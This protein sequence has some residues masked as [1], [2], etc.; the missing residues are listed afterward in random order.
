MSMKQK[1]VKFFGALLIASG[2]III[3]GS[4][5]FNRE[6]NI[7]R[8]A[9]LDEFRQELE[10]VKEAS[11]EM[12]VSSEDNSDS[13]EEASIEEADS[14]EKPLSGKVIGI[15]TI[16]S[17][18]SES[19]IREGVSQNVLADSLGHEP[20]TAEPG[21]V[22]NC[23]IAGH[24]NYNFNRFFSRLDKVK[25]GDYI[26]VETLDDTYS[27]EVFDIKVVEPDDLSVLD[28]T[29]DEII[30]LYTCTP[31]YIGT[32]RLVVSAKRVEE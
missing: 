15:L 11:L 18:E 23:V 5:A 28:N 14:T 20:D 2:L 26:Q 29:D 12:N 9:A 22:G 10:E 24:R 25:L 27:Y 4:L 6:Q 16:P 19:P 7:Q 8:Q 3:L 1:V 17:I 32:H 13:E 21:E 30:T 31:I